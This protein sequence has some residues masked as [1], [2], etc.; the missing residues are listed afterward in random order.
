[1]RRAACA[2][3][4]MVLAGLGSA[5]CF[6][7][8]VVRKSRLR[9]SPPCSQSQPPSQTPL[10][11]MDQT[12]TSL[13]SFLAEAPSTLVSTAS[14]DIMNMGDDVYGPV[15]AGGI[16][17]MFVGV[18][19]AFIVGNIIPDDAWEALANEGLDSINDPAS[20]VNGG[21]SVGGA[22]SGNQQS[23]RGKV[24]VGGGDSMFDDY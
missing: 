16:A 21:S 18:I 23:A 4:C 15:F 13:N 12:R 24:G 5:S 22:E 7:S 17:L 1:M 2:I 3:L 10:L 20:G 19:S 11:R 6:N 14:A 8:F 9:K